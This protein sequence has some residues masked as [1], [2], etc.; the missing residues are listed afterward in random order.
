MK[1]D[2]AW[3]KT[4]VYD[5]APASHVIKPSRW[6][7]P[8]PLVSTL[9]P[10]AALEP[11]MLPEALRAYVFDVAERTQCP[12]DFV[13]VC[14]LVGLAAALGNKRRIYLK[15]RDDWAEVPNLWGVIIGR[16]SAMKSPAMR[17]AL[18]PLDIIEKEAVEAWRADVA[19]L[20]AEASLAALAARDAK[21]SAA[22]ALRDGDRDN[23]RALLMAADGEGQADPPCPCLIVNSATVEALGER[24][25]EN[26]HGVISVHD[27]MGGW[28]ARMDSEERR[29]DRAFYLTAFNGAGRFRY[30]RIGRGTIVIETCTV[31][32]IGGVQP[33]RLA[34]L[35]RGALTGQADDGLIQRLQLAVF[36]DDASDWQLIDRSP[37]GPAREAYITA[38]KWLYA[39]P[40]ED[41][42]ALR[43][44]DDA[45]GTFFEWF[46]ELN[47]K[48]RAGNIPDALQSHLLK[49]PPSIASIALIFHLLEGEG[50]AV[51]R[52]STL[53]ALE[54]ADY[55]E[56]HA[57]RL[58][59][60][61]ETATANAA[62]LIQTRRKDLPDRFTAR[63]VQ[64]KG[65][66]GL[67]DREAVSDAL[68]L[69]T[70]LH[71]LGETEERTG[72]RPTKVYVWSPLLPDKE[73]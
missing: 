20:K 46:T 49:M 62:R 9:P 71:W 28:L 18:E 59:A 31:S 3:D 41:R 6:P 13:A 64:R 15:R 11:D 63:D 8:K 56:S 2:H 33:S 42:P 39:L 25:N 22:K 14:A 40:A 16:P 47:T 29:E 52:A 19:T 72:G 26:P 7:A 54:W 17:A 45:Q 27:E 66:A 68:A 36:P 12:A 43:F 37:N 55:L 58:Y 44:A 67:A 53:R 65:W 61:G 1:S 32:L 5:I 57:R 69:L 60:L 51:G 48:A 21:K 30:D 4:S 70:D 34:P 35:V 24:L 38:F 23:A 10:V 50:P 73:A